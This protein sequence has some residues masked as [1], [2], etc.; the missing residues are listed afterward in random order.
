[1]LYDVFDIDRCVV[2]YEL[3]DEIKAKW[4]TTPVRVKKSTKTRTIPSFKEKNHILYLALTTFFEAL[5]NFDTEGVLD[6]AYEEVYEVEK[7]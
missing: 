5:Y 2:V 3:H 6:E 1:M 4:D 7:V